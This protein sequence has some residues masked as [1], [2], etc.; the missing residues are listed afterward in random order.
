MSPFS[1][2]KANP[3]LSKGGYRDKPALVCVLPAIHSL[4]QLVLMEEAPL[5]NPKLLFGEGNKTPWGDGA[6]RSP[7][8]PR[9]QNQNA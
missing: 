9:G 3:P 6:T 2:I 7:P 4:A 1:L 8:P 5:G